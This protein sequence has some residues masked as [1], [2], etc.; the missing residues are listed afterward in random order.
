MTETE[1]NVQQPA[2]ASVPIAQAS[3]KLKG[4]SDK[5]SKALPAAAPLKRLCG[6]CPTPFPPHTTH[7]PS[8]THS[9]AC[10]CNR[11]VTQSISQQITPSGP[12]RPS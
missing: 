3:R 10:S 9:A 11:G 1:H 12:L 4:I 5:H 6:R 2:R 8:P 7:R